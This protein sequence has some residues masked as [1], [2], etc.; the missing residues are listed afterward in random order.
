MDLHWNCIWLEN[1][2]YKYKNDITDFLASYIT[3]VHWIGTLN[4]Y[5]ILE[6]VQT[7]SIKIHFINLNTTIFIDNIFFSSFFSPIF[8]VSDSIYLEYLWL[9]V[10]IH[11][12]MLPFVVHRTHSG[13]LWA[14]HYSSTYLGANI[15]Q[16]SVTLDVGHWRGNRCKT[17]QL[18]HI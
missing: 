16:R 6:I 9:R 2:Q 8:Q 11:E 7:F 18:C 4:I 12:N 3:L 5:S 17:K 15:V 14:N 10:M 1:E 13:K